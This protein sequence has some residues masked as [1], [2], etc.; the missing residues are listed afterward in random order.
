MPQW[1]EPVKHT[2]PDID[3]LIDSMYDMSRDAEK[4]MK[5]MVSEIDEFRTHAIAELEKL[6]SANDSLRSW[7][8]D[9]RD[10]AER[11]EKEALDTEREAAE[12]QQLADSWEQQYNTL[13]EVVDRLRQENEALA[14]EL[15]ETERVLLS[16]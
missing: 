10:E 14:A 8:C 5:D 9:W 16:K 13:E 11:I 4:A 12:A 7:G 15:Q 2:C 6:R 3:A 1:G